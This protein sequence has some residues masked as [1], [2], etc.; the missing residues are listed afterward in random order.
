MKDLCKKQKIY[1]NICCKKNNL[2]LIWMYSIWRGGRVAEGSGLLSR[3]SDFRYRGFESLPLR[4]FMNNLR[5]KVVH[6]I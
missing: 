5:S 1:V 2:H 4:F 3:R 6:L